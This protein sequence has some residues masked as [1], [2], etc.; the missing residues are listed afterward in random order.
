MTKRI[1]NCFTSD[2]ENMHRRELLDSVRQSE[3]RVLV[4]ETYGMTDPLLGDVSNAELAAAM[5]ADILLLNVFDVDHPVIRG[6]PDCKPEDTV[7]MIRKLTGRP[8]GINLE[9]VNPDPSDQ[10]FWH[11]TKGRTATAE[12]ALKAADMGVDLIMITGNPGM[13]VDNQAIIHA[14]KSI[15]AAVGDRLI[16]A[17][18][19]MHAAG[20]DEGGSEILSMEDI[21]EFSEAGADI[22]LMPAPGTVPGISQEWCA[23]RIAFIHRLHKLAITSIGTSQEGA[24]V[25]TIRRIALMAKM[26]GTDLHHIG[27]SGFNGVADPEDIMAYSIAIRGK[28]HTLHRMAASVNR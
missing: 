16:L 1:L 15:D 24:D 19:K 2:F 12:N 14:L 4:T 28:R 8:V 27:D 3:G 13:M 18:G 9:P 22:I 5:G 23:E 7:R 11:M 25:E 17:A 26:A 21:R 10:S 20:T 6:I